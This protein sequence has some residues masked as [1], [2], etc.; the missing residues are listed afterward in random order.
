LFQ[1][2]LLTNPCVSIATILTLYLDLRSQKTQLEES[3]T[4]AQCY[5]SS[6]APNEEVG[7]G[8]RAKRLSERVQGKKTRL[9]KSGKAGK[10]T[11]GKAGKA[12]NRNSRSKSPRKVRKGK[13]EKIHQESREESSSFSYTGWC[14]NQS[15]VT[16]APSM[17]V[18]P[19]VSPIRTAQPTTRPTPPRGS[20]DGSLQHPR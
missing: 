11:F 18:V 19:T 9:R 13:E 6:R 14:S 17:L 16:S 7:K 5:R 3:K 20:N 2:F 4:K 1:C 12:R 10:R 15:P 8:K